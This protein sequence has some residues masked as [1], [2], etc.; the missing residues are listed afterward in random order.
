MYNGLVLGREAVGE[1]RDRVVSGTSV[2]RANDRRT[3]R[4]RRWRPSSAFSI[5]SS[6][7][8]RVA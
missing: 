3:F 1:L 2:G 8:W 7:A 5:S 4:E 6:W